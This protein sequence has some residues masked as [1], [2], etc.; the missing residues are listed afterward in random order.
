MAYAAL[1]EVIDAGI[2]VPVAGMLDPPFP[3]FTLPLFPP[4]SEPDPEPVK[5][6]SGPV[7]AVFGLMPQLNRNHSLSECRGG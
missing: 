6:P 2:S 3:P 7:R 1:E 5:P 4:F